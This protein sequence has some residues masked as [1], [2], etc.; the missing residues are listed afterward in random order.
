M[1]RVR[2]RCVRLG[3]RGLLADRVPRAG[4][5]PPGQPGGLRAVGLSD[6]PNIAAVAFALGLVFAIGLVA[7]L[8]LRRRWYLGVCVAVLAGGPDLQ[9]QRLGDVQHAGGLRR[10]VRRPG[11]PAADGA[12]RPGRPGRGV[13][14][15]GVRAVERQPLRPRPHCP[16]RADD[17]D[18]HRVQHGQ[19]EG[20]DDRALVER[21]RAEPHRR[22]RAR[23][24]DHRA[25]T[26]TPR[27]GSLPGPQHRDP[28]LV[29]RRHLHGGSV[30]R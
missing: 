3:L 27:W 9:R 30:R 5:Q 25:C 26:T 13:P 8:G 16:H 20:G 15:R 24:D 12:G 28:R 11:P 4:V 1:H 19:P 18:E 21:D 7:E 17:G 14:P 10:P 22:A 29:R 2:P 6:Q 23:P